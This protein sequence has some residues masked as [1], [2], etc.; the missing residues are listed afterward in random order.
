MMYAAAKSLQ[1]CPTLSDPMD[2]SLPG[3]SLHRIFQAR[4]LKWVAIAFSSDVW[5]SFKTMIVTEHVGIMVARGFMGWKRRRLDIRGTHGWG[6]C[7]HWDLRVP[8]SS[9]STAASVEKF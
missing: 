3:S 7:P 9:S 6:M 2:C 8:A 1:L 4:V 5:V